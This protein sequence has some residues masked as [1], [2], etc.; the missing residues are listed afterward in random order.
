MEG[1]HKSAT[2]IAAVACFAQ[3]GKSLDTTITTKLNHKQVMFKLLECAEWKK[4]GRTIGEV[5]VGGVRGI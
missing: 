2:A 4:S 1:G 5:V 3:R